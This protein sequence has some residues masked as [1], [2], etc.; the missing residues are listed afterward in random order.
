MRK[1]STHE[2]FLSLS[3]VSRMC[4]SSCET[5][6]PKQLI[7]IHLGDPQ[8]AGGEQ[9][10]QSRL[11]S[12]PEMLLRHLQLCPREQLCLMQVLIICSVCCTLLMSF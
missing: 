9:G 8:E 7:R 11:G 12:Q 1:H 10:L 5:W 6:E 2:V 3:V 4:N